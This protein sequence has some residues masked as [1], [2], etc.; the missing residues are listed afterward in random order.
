M[1][2]YLLATCMP[3]GAFQF[4]M[5]ELLRYKFLVNKQYCL[6]HDLCT[7]QDI[8]M[9]NVRQFHFMEIDIPTFASDDFERWLAGWHFKDLNYNIASAST[10][11]WSLKRKI[12]TF[13]ISGFMRL[14]YRLIDFAMQQTVSYDGDLHR[15][16]LG[17]RKGREYYMRYSHFIPMSVRFKGELPKIYKSDLGYNARNFVIGKL[18]EYPIG[19]MDR[20]PCSKCG[21]KYQSLD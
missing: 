7:C 9:A 4:W 2:H 15:G 11:R 3:E 17:I 18:I 1:T 13:F 21:A 16:K 12:I 8:A 5:D 20:L 14:F 6:E 19:S 10:K